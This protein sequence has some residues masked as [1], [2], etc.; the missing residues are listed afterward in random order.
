AHVPDLAG[1]PRPVFLLPESPLAQ[2]T[3]GNGVPLQS[4]LALLGATLFLASL[5]LL[6]RFWWQRLQQRQVRAWVVAAV[7]FIALVDFWVL[8][9]A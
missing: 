4:L 9:L 8:L 2:W 3:A 5:L 6:A 1:R 7:L